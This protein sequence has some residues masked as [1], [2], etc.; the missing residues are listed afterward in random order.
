MSAPRSRRFLVVGIVAALLLLGALA[1]FLALRPQPEPGLPA[2]PGAQ[3]A[4]SA[5]SGPERAAL[6]VTLVSPAAGEWPLVVAANGSVAAWQ[7]AVIGAETQG[8]RL[9]E[10]RV[11]V[12]DRVRRGD[13]L[14]RLQSETTGAEVAV[15][16]ASIVE[17]E[18]ALAQARANADRARQL[19]KTGALSAQQIN[20][21]TT[22]EQ[23]AR[24][25]LVGL[26]ARLDADNVR[27]AQTRIVAPDDGVISAR[28][29][30][31][32]AVVSPGQELFR[33]IR[34]ERLEWRAE[35]PSAE[36]ARIRPGMAVKLVPPGGEA[37]VGT[38]RQVAPTVD[39]ATRNGLVY[40]DLPQPGGAKAGM[41]ARGEFET[42]HARGLT[43]P[44]GAVVLR[45][46]FSYAFRVDGEGRVSQVKLAVGRRVGD[47]IEVLE[48]L[49]AAARV[50]EQGGAFLA[51]GDVVRVVDAV[52]AP[53]AVK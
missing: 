38:V 3:G 8:L 33:L 34:R 5:A 10:V 13:L 21:F 16:R 12:G 20:E 36:L 15:T 11:Q 29:A 52:S 50:V 37:V 44:Q 35:V 49:D 27:L 19:E 25:R 1:A 14:A 47:R 30:T 24:A 48:G 26:K 6:T 45:D 17:A 2:A 18:A 40:V 51:D 43:L 9:V 22:A 39:P 41:F 7:E 46:G 32:G 23:T 4:A 28:E 53:V 31:V 42:G